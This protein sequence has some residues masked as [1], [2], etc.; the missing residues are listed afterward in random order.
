[1]ICE[2][3]YS[4]NGFENSLPSMLNFGFKLL[5]VNLLTILEYDVA[6]SFIFLFLKV[7]QGIALLS[8]SWRTKTYCIPLQDQTGK[9]PVRSDVL[10]G[11]VK[12][13][14]GPHIVVFCVFFECFLHFSESPPS[15]EDAPGEVD[16]FQIQR[17]LHPGPRQALLARRKH[18]A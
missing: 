16:C 4:V 3:I 1:M 15:Q 6:I 13:F 11:T 17:E 18:V 9:R 5:D 12:F 10:Y 7:L 2:F 14:I 8:Q